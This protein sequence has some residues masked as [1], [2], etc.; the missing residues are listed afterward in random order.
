M[1]VPHSWLVYFMENTHLKWMMPGGTPM[2]QE[3]SM[4]DVKSAHNG[5][6]RRNRTSISIF[7]NVDPQ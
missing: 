2:T 1:E 6:F 5:G 3:T 7:G 4:F